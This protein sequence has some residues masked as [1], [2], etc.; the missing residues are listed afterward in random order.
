MPTLRGQNVQTGAGNFMFLQSGAPVFDNLTVT[1]SLLVEGISAFENVDVSGII[2]LPGPGNA[3]GAAGA[4]L[5]LSSDA[6]VVLDPGAGGFVTSL[7]PIRTT[8]TITANA[9]TATEAEIAASGVAVIASGTN[10]ITVPFGGMSG[11]TGR[12]IATITGN[13]NNAGAISVVPSFNEFYIFSQ[14]IVS[15]NTSIFW[16]VVHY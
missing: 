12:I 14:N 6:D 1:N 3:I 10:N 15:A 11:A 13:F 7:R 16:L 4:N 5:A 8:S 9:G 2:S